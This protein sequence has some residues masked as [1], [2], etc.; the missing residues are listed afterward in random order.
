MVDVEEVDLLVAGGGPAGL[1]TAEAAAAA[2]LSV[3]VVHR[4]ARIGSPVRT[5]GGSWVTPLKRL[6]LPE[7]LWHPI[8]ELIFAGPTEE[9]RFTFGEDHAVVLDITATYRH[10]AEMA[11]S[12]GA[13]ILTGTRF[14]D[15]TERDDTSQVALIRDADGERSVR[16]RWIVDAT[17]QW[18]TV[19]NKAGISTG[20]QRVGVGVEWEFENAGGA[21]RRV[22]LFVGNAAAPSGYGWIFPTRRNTVRVG[23]GVMRPDTT[24]SPRQLLRDFLD[25]PLAAHWGFRFGDLVSE[26]TGAIPAAGPSRRLR[27]GNIISVGDSAGQA[28][29]LA[30]EGIRYCI[31]SGRE[32]GRALAAEAGGGEFTYPAWWRATYAR[33]F[34]LAQ[35][36][37]ENIS[38]A[39]D[40]RWDRGVRLLRG[41]DG[42][43][44]G[45]LLRMEVGRRDLR[46][47]GVARLIRVVRLGTG[48]YVQR[49][50]RR[51]TGRGGR[52]RARARRVA[53]SPQS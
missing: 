10:L 49:I 16:C 24:Q 11:R 40:R 22:V 27:W 1:A 23:I 48:W 20:F 36:V 37:N 42:D 53:T 26:H 14:L 25:T 9:A 8:D 17:G 18:R 4:D 32:L 39:D 31:E 46:R 2:G 12:S 6:G 34:S 50:V 41:L 3:L 7:H 19:L 44:M 5:S 43:Q 33:R 15:L 51:L 28:L 30:G 13:R 29:P 21:D 52:R 38:Q 45:R 35:Y 47:Y